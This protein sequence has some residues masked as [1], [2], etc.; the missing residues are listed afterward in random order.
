M[1]TLKIYE[2]EK[3][4]TCRKALKFLDE[5]GVAYER[6]PIVEQPPSKAELKRMLGFIELGGGDVRKLFN[7]SGQVY[8][9]LKLGEKLPGMSKDE[10]LALLAR[11]GKLVKR[12]FALGAKA[13]TVGFKAEEWKKL[14]G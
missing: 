6:V 2:Y 12:P 4:D 7:T 13:G 14:F 1:S 10:A 9:E 8:R 5:R 11:H 3:C